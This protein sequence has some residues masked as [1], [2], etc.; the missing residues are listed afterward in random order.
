MQVLSADRRLHSELF[1]VANP[2]DAGQR[3]T[4]AAVLGGRRVC[5]VEYLVSLGLRGSSVKYKPAISVRRCVWMSPAFKDAQ[6]S[7]AM[8]VDGAGN[9][10]G[11]AWVIFTD[12]GLLFDGMRRS[13][14]RAGLYAA[15]VTTREKCHGDSNTNHT[16]RHNVDT[17][18]PQLYVHSQLFRP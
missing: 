5:S 14:R 10:P 6:K 8:L 16:P 7:L 1:V 3:S 17:A 12:V 9:L 2:A 15:L 18:L 13:S 11:S 4:W